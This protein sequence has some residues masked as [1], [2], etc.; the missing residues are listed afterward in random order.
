MKSDEVFKEKAKDLKRC[1]KQIRRLEEEKAALEED[2]YAI[3]QKLKL[4]TVETGQDGQMMAIVDQ[5]QWL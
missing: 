4:E 1:R 2:N 5:V 3:K